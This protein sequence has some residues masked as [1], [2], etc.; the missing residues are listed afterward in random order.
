[1][2]KKDRI[3]GRTNES[4]AIIS[5]ELS[6]TK[7]YDRQ[8]GMK[9]FQALKLEGRDVGFTNG[10]LVEKH[11]GMNQTQIAD[12]IEKETKATIEALNKQK[13]KHRIEYILKREWKTK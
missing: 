6:L 11:K 3:S 4:K 1:L 10:V 2:K 5:E 13:E 8:E 12:K 7:F 9:V